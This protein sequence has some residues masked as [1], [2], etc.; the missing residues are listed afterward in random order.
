MAEPEQTSENLLWRYLSLG[1][2]QLTIESNLLRFTNLQFFPDDWEGIAAFSSDSASFSKLGQ[3]YENDSKQLNYARNFGYA[4]CWT[5]NTPDV[6][7]MWTAYAECSSW[8]AIG[9]NES[10]L[11]GLYTE[12]ET[13]R[14]KEVDYGQS[15]FIYENSL[16]ER[17]AFLKRKEFCFEQEFRL[18]FIDDKSELEPSGVTKVPRKEIT[19]NSNKISVIRPHPFIGKVSLRHLKSL[20][21]RYE[22]SDVLQ[23]P[24]EPRHLPDAVPSQAFGHRLRRCNYFNLEDHSSMPNGECECQ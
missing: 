2:L 5:R 7:T 11:D 24:V 4:S 6:M 17:A 3:I 22:L 13:F 8:V 19:F 16:L 21:N 15:N 12:N 18:F 1:A 23:V 10:Y 20:L 9:V 14:T